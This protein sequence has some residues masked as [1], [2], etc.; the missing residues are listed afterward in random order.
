[1][2]IGLVAAERG[3]PNRAV[4]DVGKEQRTPQR[5]LGNRTHSRRR[6]PEAFERGL[7]HRDGRAALRRPERVVHRRCDAP[8]EDDGTQ[9][10]GRVAPAEVHGGQRE[11]DDEAPADPAGGARQV[12]GGDDDHGDDHRETHQG[13]ARGAAEVEGHLERL[14]QVGVPHEERGDP[15]EEPGRRAGHE[16]IA[17]KAPPPGEQDRDREQCDRPQRDQVV[18]QA[19]E[20]RRAV[21][22]R[23]EGVDDRLLGLRRM[24][25]VER[26]RDEQEGGDDDPDEVARAPPR[27][28]DRRSTDD[29]APEPLEPS[30][31]HA[32]PPRQAL[33]PTG[34]PAPDR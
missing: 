26:Q 34:R 1:M 12:R 20:R 7:D 32:I 31:G 18:E 8:P 2:R 19:E 9:E 13:E 30:S 29:P 28:T 16:Q 25:R 14:P 6:H 17:G 33:S 10:V 24:V 3:D 27:L 21:G 23:V 15:T 5:L 22:Q 11:H 4:V